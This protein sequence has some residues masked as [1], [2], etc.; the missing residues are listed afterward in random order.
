[1]QALTAKEIERMEMFML[2]FKTQI[3]NLEL[4]FKQALNLIELGMDL[5]VGT[6]EL[7]VK[8]LTAYQKKFP[9]IRR[10]C[11]FDTKGDERISTLAEKE[12]QAT[13]MAGAAWFQMAMKSKD[14]SLGEMSLAKGTNEPVMIMA[15]AAFWNAGK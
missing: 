8:E 1:M 6:K 7:T 13:N 14:V 2:V 9:A 15:R 11:L 4:P 10:I 3:D 5:D 12:N